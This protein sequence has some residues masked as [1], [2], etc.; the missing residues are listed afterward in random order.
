M[1]NKRYVSC[2]K[3]DLGYIRIECNEDSLTGVSIEREEFETT[4]EISDILDK[5]Y[6]QIKEYFQRKRKKFDLK[7]YFEG[8]EFQKKV[9]NEL[10]NIPFGETISYKQLAN[11]IGN[12]KA[13]RAV[14]GANNKNPI[15]I[16]IPCHRVIGSNG[17]LVGYAGGLDLK[18]W[19]LDFEKKAL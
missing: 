13:C 10:C 1:E 2:Y 19:L 7:I 14:G 16:V 4:E 12:P 6:N 18:K 5:A 3:S 17:D 8:T 15:G 9:W 11:R